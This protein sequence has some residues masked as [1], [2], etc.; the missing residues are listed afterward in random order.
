[1]GSALRAAHCS[2]MPTPLN[3]V[4]R[5]TWTTSDRTTAGGSAPPRTRPSAIEELSSAVRPGASSRAHPRIPSPQRSTC[6]ALTTCSW[7]PEASSTST[8]TCFVRRLSPWT[9]GPA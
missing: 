9:P 3:A 8:R 4:W 1:M 5:S 7:P 6:G 2:R